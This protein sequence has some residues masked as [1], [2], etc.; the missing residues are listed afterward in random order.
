MLQLKTHNRLNLNA[1]YKDGTQPLR[2]INNTMMH[3]LIVVKGA[4]GQ[5]N[6]PYNLINFVWPP[7]FTELPTK[8]S[9]N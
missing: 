2:M 4:T 8:P 6:K 9:M 5:D 7:S 1:L 3:L